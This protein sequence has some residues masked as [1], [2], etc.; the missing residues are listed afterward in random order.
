MSESGFVV[1]ERSL[2]ALLLRTDFTGD[3]SSL[4]LRWNVS[5]QDVR[6][7]L[8]RW[9]IQGYLRVTTDRKSV[10]LALTGAGRRAR[11]GVR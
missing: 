11:H 8:R 9:M 4:A 2:M 5:G 10:T 1:A 3:P 7:V 6:A